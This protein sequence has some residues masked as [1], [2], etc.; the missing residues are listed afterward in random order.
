MLVLPRDLYFRMCAT[1]RRLLPCMCSHKMFTSMR[2]LSQDVYFHACTLTRFVLPCMCC[3]ETYTLHDTSKRGPR[4]QVTG[5][6]CGIV[7]VPCKITHVKMKLQL[8]DTLFSIMYSWHNFI[9]AKNLFKISNMHFKV[10][11]TE[12]KVSYFT[13]YLYA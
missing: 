5:I 2:V 7:M 8:I 13:T 6:Q 12:F 1:T 11:Y 10:R 4:K 3:H 9:N